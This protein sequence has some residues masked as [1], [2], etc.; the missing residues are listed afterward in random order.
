MFDVILDGESMNLHGFKATKRPDVSS[1]QKKIITSEV[2]SH[3]G[4]FYRDTGYYTDVKQDIEFN[5]MAK[6][7]LWNSKLRQLRTL[8]DSAKEMILSDD[9]QMVRRIKSASIGDCARS[10]HCI[11]RVTVSFTLD[12][13][14]YVQD[15]RRFYTDLKD[16][17]FNQWGESKPVYRIEGSG[18]ATLTVNGY[19]CAVL[20]PGVIF[21]D[22]DL[23]IAYDETLTNRN[24]NTDA[25]YAKLALLQ[26]DNDISVTEGFRLA[27]RPNWRCL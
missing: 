19:S 12:P 27:V 11:G 7:D 8:V 3:D 24:R 13:Y 10:S 17:A 26:G 18:Q 1:P 25:D 21:V 22:A 14:T 5:F 2:L 16:I 15:G 6:P 20:V 9:H 23:G 4:A